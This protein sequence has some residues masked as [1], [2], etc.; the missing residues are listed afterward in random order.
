MFLSNGVLY[1]ET[2]L[3]ILFSS[4]TTVASSIVLRKKRFEDGSILGIS[5]SISPQFETDMVTFA[6]QTRTLSHLHSI[7]T[8]TAFG[9]RY[10]S[11][12]ATLF[13]AT[14]CEEVTLKRFHQY[15]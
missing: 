1:S 9:D 4:G 3:Y 6:L 5:A 14:A 15:T 12:N 10:R 13:S 8:Y 11:V 7:P 2:Y